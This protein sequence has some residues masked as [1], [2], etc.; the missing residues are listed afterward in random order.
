MKLVVIESPYK[1]DVEGNAAYARQCMTDCL[2]RNEAPLVSHL[3]YTQV[4][5]DNDPE[6]RRKG[7]DAGH[8]WIPYADLVVAYMDRGLSGGMKFG[9]A[10]AKLTGVQVEYRW[11]GA[12]K[13]APNANNQHG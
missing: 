11:L 2:A 4:L 10:V 1:G 3:L 7:I 12:K 9:L 5:D 6:D 13:E 8:A